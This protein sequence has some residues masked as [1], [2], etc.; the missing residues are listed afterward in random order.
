[1]GWHGWQCGNHITWEGWQITQIS[2]RFC[3]FI[4]DF[5]KHETIWKVIY[6][7]TTQQIL[8]YILCGNF[9]IR[10]GSSEDP[11]RGLLGLFNPYIGNEFLCK[12]LQCAEVKWYTYTVHS[13]LK[14]SFDKGNLVIWILWKQLNNLDSEMNVFVASPVMGSTGVVTVGY[15]EGT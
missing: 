4:R 7:M 5:Y 11:S 9:A 2:F 14:W 3:W 10:K 1:M 6:F 15:I 8:L 13:T 12:T